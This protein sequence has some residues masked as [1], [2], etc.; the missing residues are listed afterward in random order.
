MGTRDLCRVPQAAVSH[1]RAK[2]PGKSWESQTKFRDG[3]VEELWVLLF[4]L[5]HVGLLRKKN[6]VSCPRGEMGTEG[7]CRMPPAAARHGRARHSSGTGPCGDCRRVLCFPGPCGQYSGKIHLSRNPEYKTM[8]VG[9][10]LNVV[11]TPG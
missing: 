3:T 11:L 10:W 9:M 7:M 6:I 2:E 5:P 8:G 1:G 4:P